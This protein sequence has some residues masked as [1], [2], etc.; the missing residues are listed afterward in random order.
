MPPKPS[1][2]APR[3]EKLDP[4]LESAG[5]RSR[6]ATRHVFVRAVEASVGTGPDPEAWK[7]IYRCEVTGAERVWGCVS[8]DRR[9][10][11]FRDN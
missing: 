5:S 6:L 8:R 1:P 4:I 11:K 9:S 2:A 10:L 3:P 7:F